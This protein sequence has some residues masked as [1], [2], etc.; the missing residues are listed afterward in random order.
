MIDP[1][2]FAS[3]PSATPNLYPVENDDDASTQ[4]VQSVKVTTI[5]KISAPSESTNSYIETDFKV[6]SSNSCRQVQFQSGNQDKSN[7]SKGSTSDLRLMLTNQTT[8]SSSVEESDED[9]SNISPDA[10]RSYNEDEQ[11]ITINQSRSRSE[12][13]QVQGR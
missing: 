2:I 12:Q 5:P 11:K 7:N 1:S 4:E 9:F 10:A 13:D 8:K 6:I 3:R